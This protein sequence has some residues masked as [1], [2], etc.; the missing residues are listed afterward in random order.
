[1]FD[2]DKHVAIHYPARAHRN[3]DGPEVEVPNAKGMSGSLLWDTKFVATT[4][5]GRNWTPELAKVC[6]LVWAA[7]PRPEVI[8]ATK[9]E[10]WRHILLH[11]LREEAAHFHWIDRGRPLWE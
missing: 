1:A 9:I 7:H 8:V 2:S 5:A 4:S 6:G 11:F 10:H 3:A